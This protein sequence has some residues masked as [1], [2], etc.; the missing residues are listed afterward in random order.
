MKNLLMIIC[1]FVATN[2]NANI[3]TL[4][5]DE[6]NYATDDTV[7]LN[8]AVEQVAPE[9]A[10]FEVD[11]AFDN[12]LLSFDNFVFDSE[13]MTPAFPAF[14]PLFTD[15][16]LS[17]PDVLSIAVWWFDATEV[18][19]TSFT[20]GVAEFKALADITASFNIAEIRQFDINGVELI[21]QINEPA[22]GVLILLSLF[23]LFYR[24]NYNA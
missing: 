17:Q 8:I 11:I 23:A 12:S 10:T 15:V 6:A 3:I 19:S 24:K 7:L 16:Y 22:T 1:L 9:M 13:M 21:S 14:G 4:N 2:V 20:L 5:T 18:P